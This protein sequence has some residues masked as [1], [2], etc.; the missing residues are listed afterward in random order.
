MKFT[1]Y[2][3]HIIHDQC[4]NS[5]HTKLKVASSLFN[6][7]EKRGGAWDPTSRDKS[8]HDVM[9]E[10][11]STTVNFESVHQFQFII[12]GYLNP[13][14]ILLHS[15]WR[16]WHHIFHPCQTGAFENM[17]RPRT[18][19]HLATL[20]M[21]YVTHVTLETRLFSHFSACNIEKLGE[22]W[23]TLGECSVGRELLTTSRLMDL[24]STV[25]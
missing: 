18:I 17:A 7:H 22:A 8:W 10:K 4:V 23:G 2:W 6:M 11:R 24:D 20:D 21:G 12:H 14:S 16:L 3:S 25:P 1:T 9:K 15:L 5:S 19:S 13:S